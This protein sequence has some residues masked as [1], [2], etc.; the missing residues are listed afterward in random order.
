MEL[1]AKSKLRVLGQRV[2]VAPVP[3]SDR[4]AGGLIVKADVAK[5][6]SCVGK[7]VA[8]GD[9]LQET[10]FTG[11]WPPLKVGEL[12][13]YSR[14]GGHELPIEGGKEETWPRILSIEEV[15]AVVEKP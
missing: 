8:I 3:D 9:G 1:T 14:Y 12:V 4:Y 10:N 11:E 15:L 6:K 2:L 5:S 7:V 13:L